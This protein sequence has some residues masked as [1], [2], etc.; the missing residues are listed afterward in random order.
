M[1]PLSFAEYLECYGESKE[2]A[3][4][5][6]IQFGGFPYLSQMENY[7]YYS[8]ENNCK[9]FCRRDGMT[10]DFRWRIS[11]ILSFSAEGIK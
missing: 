7:R 2:Q 5:N 6:Y 3:L 10:L 1:L 9:I 11:Y 4:A 8:V